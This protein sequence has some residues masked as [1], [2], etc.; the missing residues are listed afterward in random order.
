MLSSCFTLYII[1]ELFQPSF[2]ILKTCCNKIDRLAGPFW[3]LPQNTC[4]SQRPM[5]FCSSCSLTNTVHTV[6]SHYV[7]HGINS[8][9]PFKIMPAEIHTCN[10]KEKKR[11]AFTIFNECS[12]SNKIQK[13]QLLKKKNLWK[14]MVSNYFLSV[15]CILSSRD[16]YIE[17]PLQ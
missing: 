5:T 8:C 4:I 9:L 17:V 11:K 3:F 10:L 13:R 16:L 15:L 2:L 1:T 14:R 12:V 7:V 6:M